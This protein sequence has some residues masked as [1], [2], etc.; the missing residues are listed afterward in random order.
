MSE[1]RVAILPH[2]LRFTTHT[3]Y[4]SDFFLLR[5]AVTI[6]GQSAQV[7]YSDGQLTLN[8]R[9][10]SIGI[11]F[12]SLSSKLEDVL[13]KYGVSHVANFWCEQVPLFQVHFSCESALRKFL[14]YR[15]RVQNELSSL[16]SAKLKDVQHKT[17]PK[18]PPHDIPT[19][20]EARLFLISPDTV[21][22]DARV[23]AVTLENYSTCM[24]L[25]KESE[26][27]DFGSLFR[28]YRMD[29]SKLPKQGTVASN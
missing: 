22:K 15:E 9:Y 23:T 18:A 27:F 5:T 13:K 2:Q 12:P 21:K 7:G 19:A 6:N 26:L 4:Y 16:L 20:I 28:V 29:P 14:C 17:T 10:P 25:W 3:T 8:C 11:T 24:T 1:E